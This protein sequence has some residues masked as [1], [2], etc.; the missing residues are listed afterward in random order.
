MKF[1]SRIETILKENENLSKERSQDE[2]RKDFESLYTMFEGLPRGVKQAQDMG[3]KI[4]TNKYQ[5]E[6]ICEDPSSKDNL[7]T[8]KDSYSLETFKDGG[9]FVFIFND[10]RSPS[11]PKFEIMSD[12]PL[13]LSS[14]Q[15]NSSDTDLRK[16]TGDRL[17]HVIKHFE[18]GNSYK[19]N[20]A[21]IIGDETEYYKDYPWWLKNK[22]KAEKIGIDISPI[23]REEEEF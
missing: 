18:K 8:D 3:W 4:T 12:T 2:M 17:F 22:E 16:T 6:H 13:K 10:N 11:S 1:N 7:T 9:R 19:E 23:S 20:W 15:E 5:E 21:T 14:K